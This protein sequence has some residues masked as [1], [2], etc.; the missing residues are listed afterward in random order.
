MPLVSDAALA[1]I[2]SALSVVMTHT[3]TRTPVGVSAADD[4]NDATTSSGT[5]VAAQPCR[6]SA[7]DTVLRANVGRTVLVSMPTLTVPSDDPLKVGDLVSAIKDQTGAV[8]LAGPLRVDSINPNAE[9][10][11]SIQKV[12]RLIGTDVANG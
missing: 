11:A 9:I 2:R 5:P 6:Y 3:Y 7:D 1:G 12:A 10:G 4:W 8:L